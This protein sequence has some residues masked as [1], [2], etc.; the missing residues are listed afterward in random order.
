MEG[1]TSKCKDGQKMVL[2]H[3]HPLELVDLQRKRQH[4]EETDDD[5]DD[6]DIIPEFRGQC[7]RC[8]QV[9]FGFI[10]ARN[11]GTMPISTVQ[12]QE[13]SLSCLSCLL[14][15]FGLAPFGIRKNIISHSWDS[16]LPPS[17]SERISYLTREGGGPEGQDDQEVTPP[18]TKEQ[19]EG[20]VSALRSLTKDHNRK[21]KTNPIRLDFDEEDVATKDTRIVKGKEGV[22]DD[23]RKPFKEALKTPLTRRII[24]FSILEYK[25]PTNIK[26][27]DETTDPEDHLGRFAGVANS[28]EWLMP[29][30]CKMFQQTLDD[31]QE[32]GLN[33]FRK[34]ASMNGWTVEVGFIMG[35]PKIM[36]ISS[37]MDSLK[38]PEL[39]KRF[40]DKAPT[41]MNEMMK[42]L[43]DFVCSKKSFAQI[44]LPKGKQENNIKIHTSLR[45]VEMIVLFETIRLTTE[46][47]NT[48]T[49]IEGEI[50][51]PPLQG[52]RLS[53]PIPPD[54]RRLPSSS[55]THSH[56]GLPHQVPQRNPGD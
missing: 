54:Q 53:A 33:A 43:D 30:W 26:L 46:G 34:K 49:T 48:R 23:L 15:G 2:E 14:L 56:F 1:S 20:H 31:P 3:E 7:G 45:Q 29:V 50:M 24:E 19:I 28:G 35:V 39:A 6:L 9:I 10:N 36:K 32:D 16:V 8:S 13:Q 25:M 55:G 21:N 11:V 27:Y 12:L 22:D 44:E 37:F 52:K 47:L 18:L 5:D 4:S 38:C 40:S 17:E 41:T 42:R 51:P